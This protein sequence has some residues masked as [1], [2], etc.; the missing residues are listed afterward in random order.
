MSVRIIYQDIATGADEDAAVT[1]PGAAEFSDPDLL[2]FGAEQVPIATLEPFSWLLDGTREVLDE[3]SLPFW[4]TA[5]SDINGVLETPPEIT[6]DFDEHYTAPGLFLTFAPEV[7]EYCRSVTASWYRGITLLATAEFEPDA[8]EYFCAKTV[9]SFDKVVLRLNATNYPYRYAKLR[10]VAFGVSRQFLRD[11]LRDVR[12][13]EEVSIISSE[14]AVN[15]LDFTLDSKSDVEYMFQFKQPVSAFNGDSLIG[16]FYISDSTHRAPGLYNV[17]CI[18]AIGVLDEDPFPGGLYTEYPAA[19]LLEDI[20]GGHFE[21]DLDAALANIPVSGYIPACTRREALQQV[22]FVIRAVADTSGTDKIRVYRDRETMPSRISEGRIYSGGT[23]NT[24]AIV[25]AV[26]VTA[27]AYSTSGDG[28]DT[29]EINGVTYYHTT[30]VI[31]INNPNVTANDKQNVVEVKDATLV[32]AMNA[33]AIAQH[34]YDYYTKRQ[35]QRVRIVMDGE[36][37]GDHV[38]APTPWD[39]VVDG[40]ITSMSIVLSGIAA[41]DCEIVGVDVRRVGESEM[42]VCG[43][44]DCGEV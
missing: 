14:V 29:V 24:S 4:S 37:P 40:Y 41:A 17:S 5:Q 23:V 32:N 38:A 7:G 11:E 25:T 2:P 19:D 30:S 16:T 20:I 22:S 36:K 42:I 27:H 13:V 31:T 21:L 39:T 3:Q 1:A 26:R 10:N 9:E 43:E 34:L 35:T 8:P 33:P 28:T 44:F 12:V 15:T 18:D 6:F